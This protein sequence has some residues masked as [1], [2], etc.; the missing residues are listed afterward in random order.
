MRPTVHSSEP[1]GGWSANLPLPHYGGVAPYLGIEGKRQGTSPTCNNRG[2][3]ASSMLGLCTTQRRFTC[4]YPKIAFR[5]I[6]SFCAHSPT[7]CW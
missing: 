4:H 2:G 6:P 3:I 7:R 1:L 5:I